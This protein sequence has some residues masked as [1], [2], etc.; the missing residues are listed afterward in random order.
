MP[1]LRLSEPLFFEI[2]KEQLNKLF[3]SCRSEVTHFDNLLKQQSRDSGGARASA[4]ST[5]VKDKEMT[6]LFMFLASSLN[7][8]LVYTILKGISQFVYVD[9]DDLKS[10]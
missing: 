1:I 9:R 6:P 2:I 3:R 4:R 8:E 10:N 5:T 7:V